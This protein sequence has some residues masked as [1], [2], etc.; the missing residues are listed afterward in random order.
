MKK[1]KVY[2]TKGLPAS[3]KST[4]ALD[5]VKIGK[6]DIKRVNKDELR[7]MV[8]DG[9]YSKEREKF[10]LNLRDMFV[11]DAL[12]QGKNVIVDDTNLHPKHEQALSK[13]V[14]DFNAKNT[15]Y[16]AELEVMFFV[17]PLEEAIRRDAKR[18]DKSVGA[19]VIFSMYN[20]FI[21]PQYAISQNPKLPKAI[22]CD[23]DGTL[24]I[25]KDRNPFDYDKCDTDLLNPAV[26]QIL[27]RFVL[28][29]YNFIDVIFLSGRED[30][31]RIK[32]VD[33]LTKH[34]GL[35]KDYV[36]KHLFM[37]PSGD[38]RKD[39]LL[40]KELYENHVKNKFYVEFVLDDRNQVVTLWR[41]LGFPCFQVN[42]GYF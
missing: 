4:W 12:H 15:E 1:L 20:N 38:N 25:H 33:W 36:E 30:S 5:M 9:K 21:R 40:K 26:K 19:E 37:R 14:A 8:D 34:L 35:Q 28:C 10:I 31:A 24:C 29:D 32:T 42:D 13:L 3:G 16:Q 6:G 11:I 23:L 17:V 18:G 41:D 7:A 22:I 27:D 2:M 39:Y